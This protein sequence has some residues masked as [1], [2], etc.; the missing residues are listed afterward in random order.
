VTAVPFGGHP[1]LAQYIAWAASVGCAVR[2]GTTVAADGRPSRIVLIES[3]DRTRWVPIVEI[4]DSEYLV[5]TT[6][7]RLDRRLALR[8]PFFAIDADDPSR[9]Y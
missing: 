1:T 3:P 5:P 9:S 7:A 8:S 6:I 2:Y 4:L